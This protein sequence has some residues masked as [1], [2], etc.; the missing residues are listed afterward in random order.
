MKRVLLSALLLAAI[1]LHPSSLFSQSTTGYC[2]FRNPVE[3]I[4]ERSDLSPA[5]K[6][7]LIQQFLAQQALLRKTSA[8]LYEQRHEK[9]FDPLIIPVVVHILHNYGP[10]HIADAQVHSAIAKLNEEFNQLNSQSDLAAPFNTYAGNV[11][12]EFRLAQLDPNGQCTNGIVRHVEPNCYFTADTTECYATIRPYM[13]P[14]DHY[15]NIFV[16]G[17]I[18]PNVAGRSIF[19]GIIPGVPDCTFMRY[20]YMGEVGESIPAHGSVI[21]H[22]T[23]HWFSL[24]HTWGQL[25]STVGAAASCDDDDDVADTPNNAGSQTCNLFT[26]SCGSGTPGD[27]IDNVQNF[28]DYAYCYRNF[29]EGQVARMRAA[30]L[31]YPERYNLWQPANLAAT[32]VDYPSGS[33]PSPL[34]EARFYASDVVVCAGSTIDFTDDSFYDVN[35]WSWSFA[36]GTPPT[37]TTQ[38]PSILYET[39]GTYAVTLTVTDGSASVTRTETSMITVLPEDGV[40]VPY[41][42]PFTSLSAFAPEFSTVD[43]NDDGTWEFCTFAGV[44]DS[45]CAYIDNVNCDTNS[46]IDELVSRT[47]DLSNVTGAILRF[48]FAFVAKDTASKDYLYVYVSDDCG[49]TWSKRK[50]YS[51]IAGTF[52]CADDMPIGTYIPAADDWKSGQVSLGAFQEPGIR[53]KFQFVSGGGNN[54]YLDNINVGDA[55]VGLEENSLSDLELYPN[56]VTDVLQVRYT[57]LQAGVTDILFTDLLGKQVKAMRHTGDAGE[58]TVSVDCSQLAAGWYQVEVVTGDV[59]MVRKVLVY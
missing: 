15:M 6:S 42:Q 3:L 9:D 34:C 47:M 17:S 58:Q 39:P 1:L 38:N 49:T 35:G 23:G 53:V 20:D 54:V 45:K 25:G 43:F 5:Q 36:G 18:A 41:I 4:N 33:M 12:L 14:H 7:E 59:R 56:P 13:W 48:R 57:Q 55:L 26:N 2:G 44:D 40:P 32:G 30:T 27:T 16:V 21:T 50:T 31:I 24:W 8:K 51:A 10:E 29:T 22:E 11:K 37:S 46:R 28:M 19:P 52:Q